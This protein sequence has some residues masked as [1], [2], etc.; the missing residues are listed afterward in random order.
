MDSI[1]PTDLDTC[2]RV[3]AQAA[4]LDKNHPDSIAV[5]RASGAMF[6][7]LKRARRV[8]AR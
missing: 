3:L 2:L 6:K 8:A 1:D 7:D 5:Q 4:E